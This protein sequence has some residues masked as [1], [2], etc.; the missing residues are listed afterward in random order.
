MLN[1]AP[2][3]PLAHSVENL[4]QLRHAESAAKA[5]TRAW[6]VSLT[7]CLARSTPILRPSGSRSAPLVCEAGALSAALVWGSTPTAC[8][9]GAQWASGPRVCI[10]AVLTKRRL[11]ASAV[12]NAH[13]GS[14]GRCHHL[15]CMAVH[16][17]R[18][19]Q[20]VTLRSSAHSR[21]AKPAQSASTIPK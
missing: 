4:C 15:H 17:S 21:P 18:A 9:T 7:A 20:G 13:Q 14:T 19:T 11:T 10:T 1:N 8:G 6:L 2:A 3:A 16:A 12:S 5:H